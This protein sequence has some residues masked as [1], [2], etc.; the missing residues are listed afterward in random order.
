MSL[1]VVWNKINLYE[2]IHIYIN[3]QHVVVH[4]IWFVAGFCQSLPLKILG[5]EA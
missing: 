5:C 3:L 4:S 2:Y 1:Y